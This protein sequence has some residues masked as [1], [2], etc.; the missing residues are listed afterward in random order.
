MLKTVKKLTSKLINQKKI[1]IPLTSF[2]IFFTLIAVVTYHQTQAS[3]SLTV[4]GEKYKIDTH[5]KTIGDLL[6]QE[7]VTVSQYDYLSHSPSDKIAE[8]MEI[9][10]DTARPIE[11]IVDGKQQQIWT[12]ADTIKEVLNEQKI[13]LKKH[14]SIQPP[15]ESKVEDNKKI[16]VKKAFLLKLNEG[17]KI[18]EVWSTSTTVADF[19]EKQDVTV[20]DLD[21]VEPKLSS[22]LVP[23]SE[24]KVTRVKK[25]TDVVEEPVAYETITKKDA[26]L[27]KGEK[28]VIESGEEGQ[29]LKHYEVTMENG[30]EKNRTLLKTEETKPSKNQVIALGVKV[31]KPVT[32]T[33]GE[34][35]VAKEK[36]NQV[37][38]EFTANSTAYTAYCNGCS[39]KTRTGMDL[40]ANPNVKVIAVDPSVIPLGSK[41]YVEGYGYAV[42]ADTGG[43]IKGTRIDVF[44]S[45]KAQAYKWGRRSVKIKVLN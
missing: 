12:T 24:V 38:K 7:G 31:S 35:D 13:K 10:F 11:L 29:V 28:K 17:N 16:F 45:D 30:Y 23:N 15:L 2:S 14:D 36:T 39:G 27:E 19:L 40:R 9:V 3:V 42:A 25:V 1:V 4:N 41:V 22:T 34:F 43:D 5:E 44:F 21:R 6:R 37:E 20:N 26:S 8:G 18:K 32:K 33:A